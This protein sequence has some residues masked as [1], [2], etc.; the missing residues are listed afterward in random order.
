MTSP[1]DSQP[2]ALFADPRSPSARVEYAPLGEGWL[3]SLGYRRCRDYDIAPTG[4][5]IG[6][7]D[8]RLAYDE[9]YAIGV[10]CDGVSQSFYGNLAAAAATERLS[11]LLWNRRANPPSGAELEAAVASI[12]RDLAQEVEGFAI[13]SRLPE[14]VRNGLEGVRQTAGS[15]AVFVAFVIDR[16]LRKLSAYAVGDA[17]LYAF[18]PAA[19][20]AWEAGENGGFRLI[21]APDGRLRSLGGTSSPV[22]YAVLENVSG[23]VLHSDGLP[24]EWGLT[25]ESAGQPVLED[26]LEDWSEKDDASLV[27][28]L[29]SSRAPIV[30]PTRAADE[31]TVVSAPAP[32]KLFDRDTAAAPDPSPELK[33]RITDLE[34]KNAALS[35]KVSLIGPVAIAAGLGGLLI[36]AGFGFAIAPRPKHP[37][38]PPRTPEVVTEIVPESA[39]PKVLGVVSVHLTKEAAIALRKALAAGAKPESFRPPIQTPPE[40]GAKSTEVWIE[41]DKNVPVSSITAIT[42]DDGATYAIEPAP[43]GDKKSDDPSKG[44]QTAP[45]PKEAG[46]K[47]AEPQGT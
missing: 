18:A 39:G 7:D 10:L 4:D 42:G 6:Q 34:K 33:R 40:K 8:A 28:V 20:S 32:K 23:V 26:K 29:D 44:A 15:Q 45:K 19:N 31:P 3:G 30:A 47:A 37:P 27:F 11:A 17:Y 2:K 14:V 41:V 21:S 12:E 13:P 22:A 43:K 38:K 16:A 35:R 1:Q 9:R 36:G 25:L 24:P 46:P 5:G